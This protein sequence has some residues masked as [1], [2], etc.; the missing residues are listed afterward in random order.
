MLCSEEGWMVS[1]HDE[2]HWPNECT[3]VHEG[4]GTGSS[5]CGHCLASE[6]AKNLINKTSYEFTIY[7]ILVFL[8]VCTNLF[9]LDTVQCKHLSFGQCLQTE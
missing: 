2:E 4:F 3:S 7:F 9:P 6:R 5:I 1:G 8:E